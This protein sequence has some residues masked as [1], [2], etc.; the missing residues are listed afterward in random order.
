MN[1]QQ[2]IDYRSSCPICSN[3]LLNLSF[4]TNKRQVLHRN[5]DRLL[6]IFNLQST[7][8]GQ[9]NYKAGFSID[10]LTNE[11]YIDFYDYTSIDET[12]ESA[13]PIFLLNRFKEFNKSM[14]DYRFYKS[15]L[16]CN[17]Y[18]YQSQY[19]EMNLNNPVIEDLEIEH[20]VFSFM[21][22]R[23]DKTYSIL[24]RNEFLKESSFNI[25]TVPTKHG[26]EFIK[27]NLPLVNFTTTEEVGD[28]LLN[29]MI[30]S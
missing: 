26:Q 29:L 21:H 9:K 22:K 8:K 15:C 20:E 13:S 10:K 3:T 2:F 27:F 23:N 14:S 30:F 12:Y 28:R 11:F 16:M 1:V 7:K 6:V 18:N 17:C 5:G 4:N 25:S 19:F 24:L